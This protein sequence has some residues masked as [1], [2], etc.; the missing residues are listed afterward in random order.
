[1]KR[2]FLIAVAAAI[3]AQP[4]ASLPLADKKPARD[5]AIRMVGRI[6]PS[7]CVVDVLPAGAGI[8]SR[9][10][11]RRGNLGALDELRQRTRQAYDRCVPRRRC[12]TNQQ[13]AGTP[14]V[15]DNPFHT[16][17]FLGR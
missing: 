17:P 15:L 14:E 3:A 12:F 4:V 5:Q 8:R 10:P 16:P 13:P 9:A 11:S 7:G 6:A 1:M 2:H